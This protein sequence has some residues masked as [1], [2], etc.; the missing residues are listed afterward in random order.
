MYCTQT[1]QS[2]VYYHGLWVFHSK[3]DK[4]GIWSY[5]D[6]LD[7]YIIHKL[8]GQRLLLPLVEKILPLKDQELPIAKKEI[9]KRVF[10][11][12][13]K[14]RDYACLQQLSTCMLKINNLMCLYIENYIL[15]YTR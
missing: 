14:L 2:Q 5:L 15:I 12:K 10:K 11:F 7:R 13:I 4:Y 6:S 1:W 3:Q 9:I 8:K